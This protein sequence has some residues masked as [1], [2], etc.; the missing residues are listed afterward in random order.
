MITAAQISDSEQLALLEKLHVFQIHGR[1]K[2]GRPILRVIAKFFPARIVSV[3]VLRKYLE[4]KIFPELENKPFAVVYVHTGVQRCENFPG[5]SALRS[6]YDAI[7]INVKQNLEAVYFLHPGLQARLFLATFGRFLFTGG[8]YGKLKYVS[9]LDYLW[10]HVRRS[11]IDVPDFVYDHD[12]DLEHRPMMDYGLESDHP[13][14]YGAPAVDSSESMYS[15][16]QRIWTVGVVTVEQ[17]HVGRARVAFSL[18]EPRRRACLHATDMLLSPSAVTALSLSRVFVGDAGQH[19]VHGCKFKSQSNNFTLK[20]MVFLSWAA[21]TPKEQKACID[22]SGGFNYEAKFRGATAK[23]LSSLQEDKGLSEN[24][25]L[26]NHARVLVGSGLETYEK[27]K[28]ALQD[29]RHF[30]LNWAFVDP[31]TPVQNGVKFCVCVKEFLPWVMMPLQIVYVN[32]NKSS[33][34]SMASFRFGGGTLQGHLLA[35]EERF[36]IELDENNQ[37]WY[38]IL[39]FSKPAHVLSFVGYPYVML[40]QR[41][42]AH[43]STNAIKKHLKAL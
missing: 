25:F 8:V 2:R 36:S 19:H 6:I 15:M 37:V 10:E 21:P 22:R 26:C 42:F 33:K 23:S 35:G 40:R 29:W 34:Q 16:S 41:Y 30:G 31:K 24:G 5:I 39:S 14:V 32:E 1:D 27:G 9:R 12:E 4:E 43:H 3:D 38:E 28:R 18:A 13:R 17:P 11:E 20:D 7:P